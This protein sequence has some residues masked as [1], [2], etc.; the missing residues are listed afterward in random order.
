MLPKSHLKQITQLGQKK[1]RD[2]TNMF[3]VEGVKSV[4]DFYENGWE[5]EGIYA[6]APHD[7]LPV[8]LISESDMKRITQFKTASPIL[9]VFKKR[10]PLPVST[11]DSVIVLDRIGDPGNLGTIIRLA[12]WF[13]INQIVC[14]KDTV[15]CYNPKVVQASMGGVARVSCYY[16]DLVSFLALTKATVYGAGLQGEAVHTVTFDSPMALVFG[17]ESHGFR[18][19]VA[20]AIQKWITIPSANQQAVESLNVAT[21]TAIVLSHSIKG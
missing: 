17:S 9:G 12:S 7:S 1:F 13:G 20:A 14:S 10:K 18:N 8:Q 11:S 15:D 4:T 3:L 5:Y 6:V 2:Q 19:E 16:D 21:A